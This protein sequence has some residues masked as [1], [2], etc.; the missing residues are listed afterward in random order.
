M[1]LRVTSLLLVLLA[2][3]EGTPERYYAPKVTKVPYPVKSHGESKSPADGFIVS[4]SIS[5]R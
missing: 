1:D 3:A 4:R 5:W 2:L